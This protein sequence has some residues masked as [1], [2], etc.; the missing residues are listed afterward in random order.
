MGVRE[1]EGKA[2]LCTEAWK[3]VKEIDTAVWIGDDE[4]SNADL[5]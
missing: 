4:I 1:G 3:H 2:K 5:M